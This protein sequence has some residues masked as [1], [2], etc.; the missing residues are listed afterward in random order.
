[1]YFITLTYLLHLLSNSVNVIIVLHYLDLSLKRLELVKQIHG[2][3]VVDF[4]IFHW[5]ASILLTLTYFFKVKIWNI[6]ISK[7]VRVV[8]KC[9]DNFCKFF[10]FAIEWLCW[11]N[12]T[13]WPWHTFWRFEI[14]NVNI[15]E[16]VWAR[17]KMHRPTFRDLDICQQMTP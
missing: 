11:E 16:M 14:L 12:F 7:S 1:M 13:P 4:F 17:T 10:I 3:I 2:T 8:A 15:L 6:N 5:M 9:I